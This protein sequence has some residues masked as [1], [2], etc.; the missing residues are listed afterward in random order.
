MSN[1]AYKLP[2]QLVDKASKLVRGLA[3]SILISISNCGQ[4]VGA[5]KP[6]GVTEWDLEFRLMMIMIRK[7]KERERERKKPSSSYS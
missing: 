2:I 5:T 6:S 3:H 1:Y 4:V 7:K